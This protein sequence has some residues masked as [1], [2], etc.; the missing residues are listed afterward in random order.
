MDKKEPCGRYDDIIDLPYHGAPERAH[1]PRLSRAAQFAPFAA[2]TGY[3]AEIRETAR[4]TRELAELD[5]D[6]KAALDE[7]LRLLLL[8][9]GERPQVAIF[10]FVPD[11]R[12]SGG[13]YVTV[14]GQFRNVDPLARTVILED[15]PPVPIERIYEI[16]SALFSR[17]ED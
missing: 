7:K 4:L 8:R 1:M 17:P 10:C 2:L 9:R 12:K 15:A 5:E 3:D 14:T 16:E 6:Q 11:G 13:A